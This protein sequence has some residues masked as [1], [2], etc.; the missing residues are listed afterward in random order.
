MFLLFIVG[1]I[2]IGLKLLEVPF[3]KSK[4]WLFTATPMLLFVLSLLLNPL[5]KA[6]LLVVL[7]LY[8]IHFAYTAYQKYK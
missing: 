6:L 5:G 1:L 2:M 3:M 4:S 7:G 8:L